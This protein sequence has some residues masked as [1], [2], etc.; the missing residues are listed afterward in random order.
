MIDYH[1]GLLFDDLRMSSY[2]EAIGRA[3]RPGDVVLDLGCGTGVLSLFACEAGASKVYAIEQ[4]HMADVARVLVRR[5]GLQDRI[6]I[7]HDVSTMA[8]LPER[9]NVLVTET[10]GSFAFDEQI[11][12]AVLDARERLLVAG[13]R[14]VPRQLALSAAAA[15]LPDDYRKIVS[16]W[17]ERRFGIDVSPLRVFESNALHHVYAG[18]EA[19]VTEGLTVLDADL[20]TVESASLAGQTT[21]VARRDG[22]VH[23][24]VVWFTTTLADGVT[25]TS[26]DERGTHWSQGFLPLE[27]PVRV[28]RGT[29][30]ELELDTNDGR[31]WGWRGSVGG[32]A[33]DQNSGFAMPP[34]SLARRK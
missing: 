25:L 19:R 34:C 22:V 32:T 6:E 14:V 28:T 20:E 16:S 33:F 8:E 9:A 15:E 12:S 11:L 1:R 30:I 18:E 17:S 27:Q 3:V 21:L 31:V 13:A 2:R 4:T 10:I 5:A 26:R 7:V 29:E 23:G 24:F